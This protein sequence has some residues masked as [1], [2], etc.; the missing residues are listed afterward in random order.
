MGSIH[1]PFLLIDFPE[2]FLYVFVSAALPLKVLTIKFNTQKHF[3]SAIE[4]P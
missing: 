2:E 4:F 1:F 3:A